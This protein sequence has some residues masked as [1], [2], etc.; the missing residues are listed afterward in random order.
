VGGAIPK[1]EEHFMDEEDI[2]ALIRE[3]TF[4]WDREEA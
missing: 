4:D 1:D 2:K 3:Q